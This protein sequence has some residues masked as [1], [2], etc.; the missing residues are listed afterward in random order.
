MR[1][2]DK[3]IALELYMQDERNR[4][5]VAREFNEW[6]KNRMKNYVGK[7]FNEEVTND[8]FEV[9]DMI[10]TETCGVYYFCEFLEGKRKGEIVVY[11][12]EKLA[13]ME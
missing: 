3:L 9:R 13:S 11:T 1:V 12:H 2:I 6:S 10:T 7:I 4:Q 5:R 8:M